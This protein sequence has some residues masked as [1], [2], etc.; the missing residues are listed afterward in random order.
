MNRCILVFGMPRSGTTWIGKLF[1]S[2]PDTLYRHEPDS[3]RRLSLPLYPETQVAPQYREELE[4][5][6]ASLPRLRSPKVVGKQPLFPKSY[7]SAVALCAYRVSVTFAKATSRVQRNVPCFYRPTAERSE[8]VRLVWKSIESP[9]RLGVCME[10]LPDARAIHLMRHPCGY[11]AS[12]L[13]GEAGRRFDGL[14]PSAEDLW[15]L[16]MLL[17]TSAGKTRGLSLDDVERLT[18]EERLAWR[19]VLTQEKILAD[20]ARCGRV[21][22]LRYEDVCAEPLVMTRQ[23]FEFTGLDWQSQT[24]DFIRASTQ[25]TN[26][27]MDTD[28]YSVFKRSQ[29]SAGRW[30]EELAPQVIERILRIFR[31]SPLYRLYADDV[32]TPAAPLPEAIP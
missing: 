18:P 16:K 24:E 9:G 32:Q 25:P 31:T 28:Y 15:L 10:S 1:D 7:Q 3:V 26:Q 21:L 27:T 14:T 13:R 6:V 19:W 17:A 12:V 20:V 8:Q 29:A 2:H 11:V 22:T 23:M 30:R 5:F 4:Q